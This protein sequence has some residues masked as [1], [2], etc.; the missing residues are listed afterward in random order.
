MQGAHVRRPN[1]HHRRRRQMVDKLSA[2]LCALAAALVILPLL[3]ILGFLLLRGASSMSIGLLTHMPKPVGETGGGIANAIVGSGVILGI[4][5]AIGVPIGILAGVYVSEFAGLTMRNFV[6]F[7]ADV[8]NGVPSIVIGLAVY[9]LIVVPQQHFSAFAGGVALA[10][11]MVPTIARTTEEALKLVPSN[12][13]EAALGLGIVE[14]NT[15]MRIVLPAAK[16]GIT[17]G[18]VLGFARVA[19][20]TAPLLFT[21]FGNQFWSTDPRQPISALPLQIFVYAIS[22]YEDWHRLGWAAA[23]LLILLII[24]AVAIVRIVTRRGI[25]AG[26]F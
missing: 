4:A 21:A 6:R 3:A 22:P 11:M 23:L 2:I 15:V 1:S 12:I 25:P 17:T 18:V 14:W 13:R 20:E 10:I 7:M 19:G 5:L 26:A 24:S 16:T 9:A 8:L